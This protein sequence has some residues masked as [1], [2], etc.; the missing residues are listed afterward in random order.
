MFSS[1]GGGS[2]Y[3]GGG[4]FP[5]L[6]T[7]PR[8]FS[9]SNSKLPVVSSF[10]AS[11][12]VGRGGVFGPRLGSVVFVIPPSEVTTYEPL[13]GEVRN[14]VLRSR[15]GGRDLN[16]F[17]LAKEIKGTVDEEITGAIV[18]QPRRIC[19]P[20]V[21]NPILAFIIASTHPLKSVSFS[22]LKM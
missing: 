21:S 5:P 4:V 12:G 13:V 9:I 8:A 11:G 3:S 6:P 2:L 18:S 1:A 16:S 10:L 15:A 14:T 7:L 22:A 19:V 20:L 17:A